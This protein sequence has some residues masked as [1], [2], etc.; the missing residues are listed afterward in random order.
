MID[1]VISVCL[2]PASACDGGRADVMTDTASH[3]SN[4]MKPNSAFVLRPL[5]PNSRR[6]FI[7]VGTLEEPSHKT[8]LRLF[9]RDRVSD[10]QR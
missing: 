2:I 7:H 1:S 5:K 4:Q 6:R 10:S 9:A 8:Q 3:I